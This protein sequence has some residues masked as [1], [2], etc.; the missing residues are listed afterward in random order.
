M[1]LPF[2]RK[3]TSDALA[4]SMAGIKLGDRLLVVGCS[5]PLLIAQLAT[6]TGLTGRACAVDDEETTVTRA[7]SV[8]LREGALVETLVSPLGTLPLDPAAFDVVVVRGAL[9]RLPRESR[10]G[11]LAEVRRV[12]RPGGRCL[13]IDGARRGLSALVGTASPDNAPVGLLEAA[14]FKAARVL[15]EREGLAFAE[16]VKP[17]P[18]NP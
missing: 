2:L 12:L 14:G 15:A 3:S 6:K 16:A 17:N 13:V 9:S 5:D 7:A 11:C 1:K 10:V 18:S 4:V 8:A